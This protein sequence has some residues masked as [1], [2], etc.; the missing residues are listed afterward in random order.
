[1]SL[2]DRVVDK[3]KAPFVPGSA[4]TAPAANEPSE[5]EKRAIRDR[6]LD[7]I[8]ER[9]LDLNIETSNFCAASCVFCPNSKVKRHKTTMDM[10]LFRKVID[11]YVAI[12]GGALGVSSMQSDVFSDKLLLERIRYIAKHKAS[13]YV[14]TTTFLA[15]ASKFS[16]EDLTFILSNFDQFQI[17]LGGTDK[18][19]YRQMYGI[20]AFD[21]VKRQLLRI[22]KLVRDNNLP[23]KLSLYFRTTDASTIMSSDLMKELGESY[24][25]VEARDTFFSW[26]GIISQDD[27]PDGAKLQLVDNSQVRADCAVSMA[28]LSVNV[29]GS[30]VGC[31]CVDWNAQHVIGN[32]T[33]NTIK[34][35]WTARPAVEFRTA[36][37][38][39]AVPDLCKDCSLY[40]SVDDAFGKRALKDYTPT[41]G[42][43]YNQG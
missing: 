9:P 36:F 32:L 37:S 4:K 24:G 3:L 39:G 7:I 35:A 19:Q 18:D 43:Y 23:V 29:D 22:A 26:G 40:L 41:D 17:S 13:L 14:Y 42:L 15:G 38:R 20:N 25:V 34:E 33:N 12:G 27:L 2:L 16:D 21:V 5:A 6:I 1:M 11:D 28:S 31:G 30:I 10:E 8:A